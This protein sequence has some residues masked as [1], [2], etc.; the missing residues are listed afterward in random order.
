M[1]TSRMLFPAFFSLITPADA[2]GAL[3]I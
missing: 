1:R 3:G 2:P